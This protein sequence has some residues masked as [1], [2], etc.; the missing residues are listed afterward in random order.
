MK[1]SRLATA[2]IEATALASS[3]AGRPRVTD[4]EGGVLAAIRSL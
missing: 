2:T 3:Q 4:G 1:R